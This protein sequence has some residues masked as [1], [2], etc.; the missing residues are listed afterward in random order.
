MTRF[1]FTTVTCASDKG[2]SESARKKNGRETV[3]SFGIMFGGHHTN[4]VIL[5]V[6]T[7]TTVQCNS[8]SVDS[9]QEGFLILATPLFSQL[10]PHSPPRLTQYGSCLTFNVLWCAVLAQRNREEGSRR[11]VQNKVITSRTA[12]S[13]CRQQLVGTLF[14]EPRFQKAGS[15]EFI[16]AP[17]NPFF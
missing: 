13:L 5:L 4:N 6:Y 15:V 9:F 2:G 16:W 10:S 14:S 12:S 17:R 7:T 3:D 8:H 1:L 11:D